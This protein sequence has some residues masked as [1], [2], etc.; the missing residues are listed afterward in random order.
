MHDRAPPELIL[1]RRPEHYKNTNQR[2]WSPHNRG[3]QAAAES[4]PRGLAGRVESPVAVEPDHAELDAVAKTGKTAVLD[5]RIIHRPRLA[6]ADHRGRRT[7]APGD[8]VRPPGPERDL[9]HPVVPG[10]LQRRVPERAL[11]VGEA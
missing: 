10:D 1:G 7:I 11:L 9:V 6:I 2:T 4:G 5:D 3:A 8:I